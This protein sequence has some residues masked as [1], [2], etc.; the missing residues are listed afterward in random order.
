MSEAPPRAGWQPA[1]YYP[2]PAI[3]ALD[4]RFEKYPDR[5]MNWD[6]FVDEFE[7]W[8]KTLTVKECVAALEKHGVPC[9]PYLTVTEAL[10]DPQVAHRGSLCE[11]EDGAG[12]YLSPAP[13]FRFSGSALR[14]G[15]KVANLGE[16]TASVLAEAGL[17]A[18]E[19]DGLTK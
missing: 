12:K 16:H 14:S 13:P 3:H 19:I 11:I 8:S 6:Q 9:S 2:D 17:S 1:T 5:R 15:P 4:P 10:Q 18:A 7:S